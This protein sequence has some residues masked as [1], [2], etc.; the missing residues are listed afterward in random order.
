M[1]LVAPHRLRRSSRD[2]PHYV[3]GDQAVAKVLGRRCSG[4]LYPLFLGHF[5][6]ARQEKARTSMTFEEAC[7]QVSSI[8]LDALCR[9]LVLHHESRAI[10][11][12]KIR[13]LLKRIHES[14][15]IWQTMYALNVLMADAEQIFTVDMKLWRTDQGYLVATGIPE[16]LG[17]DLLFAAGVLPRCEHAFKFLAAQ[18]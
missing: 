17:Y 13:A 7:H 14:C 9:G 5:F 3:L 1:A 10:H 4:V 8:G 11:I 15:A 12:D 2:T 16:M 18:V 6:G